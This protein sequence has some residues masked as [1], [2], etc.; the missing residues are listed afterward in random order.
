MSN[1]SYKYS[2]LTFIFNGYD[3]VR[4][5]LFVDNDVE[6]VLV[7]D[8]PMEHPVW[9]VVVDPDL[10]GK[11]PI[12]QSYYVR[13][14]PFKYLHSDTAVVIDGSIKVLESLDDIVMPFIE[15]DRDLMLMVSNYITIGQ[16]V[17]H[18]KTVRHLDDDSIAGIHQLQKELN[19]TELYGSIANAFKICVN[20]EA[21]RNFH[22]MIWAYLLQCGV[23]GNPN[24]LD[25]VVEH[26]ILNAFFMHLRLSITSTQVIHSDYLRH[27]WHNSCVEAT[28]PPDYNDYYFLCNRP[29]NPKRYGDKHIYPT[30]YK[31]NT[32]A[33]LITKYLDET[34]L[35][36]WIDW[37]LNVCGFDHIQIFANDLQFNVKK[38]SSKYDDS[39]VTIVAKPGKVRQYQIY[40][41]Y[42]ANQSSAKWVM[43]IDDDEYL[44]I[45]DEF[46]NIYEAIQYYE[47]KMPHLD[48]LAVR[49]KHLFPK[50][51]H[52]E[53]NGSVLAYCT[54]ENKS[55]AVSFTKGGDRT[56]KTIVKRYGRIHYEETDENPYGGHV[57]KHS[58]T[59]AAKTFDMTNVN[60]T[61][62]SEYPIDTADEK[63]RLLHCR[64]SGLAQW[65]RKYNNDDSNLNCM[66]ICDIVPKPKKF[67]FNSLLPYLD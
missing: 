44:S 16:K 41:D 54:E 25:E 1:T 40:N 24:R 53:R 34:D 35:D 37:H 60:S 55:L 15:A 42:L 46:H 9:N 30:H 64:F 10:S 23:N 47:H 39:R 63:I 12:Y 26:M 36:E 22:H 19:A 62:L 28:A 17:E 43:P 59:F 51:F 57:P 66:K 8:K 11:D 3:M 58:C 61:S 14:H 31:Y 6:Y 65:N 4:T 18:W 38:Y 2:I 29:V 32:E 49:W 5:P 27:Y 20:N 56:V 45:S 33:V 13:Y 7:T 50:K 21:C 67:L 52:A 48:M